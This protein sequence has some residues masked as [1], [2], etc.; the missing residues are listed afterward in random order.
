[1]T[2]RTRTLT[3]NNSFIW[4]I[5]PYFS[6]TAFAWSLR[7]VDVTLTTIVQ[8]IWPVFFIILTDRLLRAEGRFD[9]P[10]VSQIV[11]VLLGFIGF[12]FVVL[13]QEVR[14]GGLEGSALSRIHRSD[15][16]WR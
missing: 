12:I 4:V 6:F 7:Y 10:T 14:A 2:T 3:A 9:P 8:E 15:V 13:S 5:I 11:L 16:R 1:M